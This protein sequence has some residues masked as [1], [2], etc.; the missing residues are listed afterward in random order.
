MS[1]SVAAVP[2]PKGKLPATLEGTGSFCVK[3]AALLRPAAPIS[4]PVSDA[5]LVTGEDGG[6]IVYPPS[7]KLVIL[8]AERGRRAPAPIAEVEPPPAA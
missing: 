4:Q 7:D 1:W 3:T 2:P 8:A 6:V 5:V